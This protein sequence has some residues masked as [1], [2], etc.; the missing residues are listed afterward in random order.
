MENSPEHDGFAGMML[1]A[2]PSMDDPRFARSVIYLCAH[3]DDGAMGF[4]VNQPIEE[5]TFPRVADQLGIEVPETVPDLGVH[6]GGP[7]E[8]NRGF[9][10][11]SAEY[12]QDSTLVVDGTYALTAT[13]EVLKA[14]AAGEGPRRRFLALGYA[15][16]GEGQL[17]GEI[18]RNGWL[19]APADP[20]IVFGGDH[21]TK[22]MR[23]LG[24][25]GVTPWSLSGEAGHA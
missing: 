10:L 25:I 11:H 18:Q 9:V 15:G 20:D 16:W 21:E 6:V 13:I 12:V 3:S 5:L 22:W 19:I 8:T 4:I 2:M 23:A 14:I 7:V 1:I 17:D 24:T